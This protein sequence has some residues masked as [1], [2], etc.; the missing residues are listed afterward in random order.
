MLRLTS[1]G[2]ICA[3]LAVGLSVNEAAAGGGRPAVRMNQIQVLATHNSYHQRPDRPLIPEE[4]ADYEHPP[5]EVQLEEQGIRGL[6]I[7]PFNGPSLPVLHTPRIDDV[8]TCPT[9]HDC[10]IDLA[11]WHDAHPNHVPIFVLVDPKTQSVVL[12]PS[13]VPWDAAAL[14]R[15]DEEIRSVFRGASLL[16]PDDVRGRSRTLRGAVVGRGWPTLEKSRGRV[17]FALNNAKELRDAYLAGRPSL[18]GRAMFVTADSDAPS[19]AFIK[20]DQPRVREIKRLV[21][22]GFFVRTLADS[23]AVEARAND[24]TRA[25]TAIRSGAQMVTTDYPVADP[26]IGPYTVRVAPEGRPAR[27]NPVNAPK[28]CK[29]RDLERP[30]RQR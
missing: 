2:L 27:C 13:L 16:E 14:D 28:G 11:R 4:P 9:F 26:T 10:L 3:V 30:R 25:D 1:T 8:S 5:F 24:H 7:D 19:A 21:R 17:A 22:Q 15:L 18:E 20:R 12:D 23:N 6:E 29:D